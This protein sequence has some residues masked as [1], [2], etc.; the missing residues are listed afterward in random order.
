MPAIREIFEQLRQWRRDRQR[1][2]KKRRKLTQAEVVLVSHAKS[3]RT[4]LLTMLSHYYCVTRGIP[5]DQLIG[6]DNFKRYDARIPYLFYTAG[7]EFKGHAD[8]EDLLGNKK[9][10]FLYRDPRDV[11]VSWF[12]H[13][14]HRRRALGRSYLFH[15]HRIPD[16]LTPAVAFQPLWLPR[17]VRFMNEW[18]HRCQRWE[19]SHSIGYERMRAEPER[20]LS[21]LVAFIDGAVDSEAVAKAVDFASF[22]NMKG[23]ERDGFFA[24]GRLSGDTADDPNS[25][26]VRRGKIGG[27][28]E[29]F[30][31]EEVGLIDAYI[32]SHIDPVFGYGAYRPLGVSA[33]AGG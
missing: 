11:V 21:E 2:H 31:A 5:A 7:W 13:L 24:S 14:A 3:G 29:H 8:I 32:E 12:Y 25:F 28:R 22:D 4:W 27:Y 16:A 9:V 33:N 19:Q 6:G 10:I 1:F 15:G 30:R 18:L 20:V 23:L 17:I 26:K